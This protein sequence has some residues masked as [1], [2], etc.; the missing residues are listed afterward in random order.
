VNVET[1][2]LVHGNDGR[3]N[4]SDQKQLVVLLALTPPS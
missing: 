4:F 3:F 1:I 2:N